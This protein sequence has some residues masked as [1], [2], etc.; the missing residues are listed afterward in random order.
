M[1]TY[2]RHFT[3]Q[4]WK[5]SKQLFSV[6]QRRKSQTYF[7]PIHQFK[8]SVSIWCY[9][10][11]IKK[12][13]ITKVYSQF[14]IDLKPLR[15]FLEL[16]SGID[17]NHEC[18]LWKMFTVEE[19]RLDLKLIIGHINKFIYRVESRAKGLSQIIKLQFY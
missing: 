15:W 11:V 17:H 12:A 5:T 14:T 3:A 16:V 19:F 18:G 6:H 7:S 8:R 4:L 1:Q 13:K 2:I 10:L 9:S